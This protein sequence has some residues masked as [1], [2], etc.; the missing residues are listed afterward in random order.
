MRKSTKHSTHTFDEYPAALTAVIDRDVSP[1]VP[2]RAVKQ[3]DL[4]ELEGLHRDSVCG[5]GVRLLTLDE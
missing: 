2:E 5:V 4:P 3:L 1:D